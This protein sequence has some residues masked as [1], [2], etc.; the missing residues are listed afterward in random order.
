MQQPRSEEQKKEL[1]ELLTSQIPIEG[2][3]FLLI[4]ITYYTLFPL[5]T[6]KAG[7]VYCKFQKQSA[8]RSP[9]LRVRYIG[10]TEDPDERKVVL[11]ILFLNFLIFYDLESSRLASN[12]Q[13]DRPGPRPGIGCTLDPKGHKCNTGQTVRSCIIAH[14]SYVN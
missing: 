9:Y 2:S 6:S 3:F 10:W 5:G 13:L 1:E 4:I 8:E 12:T 14:I 11:N 7:A